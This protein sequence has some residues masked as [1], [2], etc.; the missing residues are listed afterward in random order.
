MGA[1]SSSGRVFDQAAVPLV[2]EIHLRAKGRAG[3]FVVE[4]GEEGII[5]AI[6]NAARVQLLGQDASASVDLPTRIGPSITM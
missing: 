4:I 2:E 1:A 3:L 5:L 6:E